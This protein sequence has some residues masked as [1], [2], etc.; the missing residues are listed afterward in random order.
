M[1]H[2]SSAET[3]QL[4]FKNWRPRSGPAEQYWGD[5]QPLRSE[6]FSVDQMKEHGKAL[7]TSHES[8][9]KPARDR[10]LARLGENEEVLIGI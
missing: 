1:I 10:L 3:M 7:A 9:E 2:R 6:L 5:E 4:S 8:S